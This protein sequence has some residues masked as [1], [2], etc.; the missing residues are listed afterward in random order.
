MPWGV[1]PGGSRGRMCMQMD[2]TG[3][4]RC[5]PSMAPRLDAPFVFLEFWTDYEARADM[6]VEHKSRRSCGLGE[7][8][9]RCCA[10]PPCRDLRRGCLLQLTAP[11]PL[12]SLCG[13]SCRRPA[14]TRHCVRLV[15]LI[16][17]SKRQNQKSPP[18]RGY[19]FGVGLS[20][21]DHAS[22]TSIGSSL[23]SPAECRMSSTS[24]RVGSAWA[25][26]FRLSA[27]M[28]LDVRDKSLLR[29]LA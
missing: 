15:S 5:T 14:T 18:T 12:R 19:V 20:R 7:V 9:V 8:R 10:I 17:V 6:L 24:V 13:L 29:A 11:L 28:L 22:L 25:A 1:D 26:S 3:P 16:D 4:Y 27:G 2:R 23:S 21:S